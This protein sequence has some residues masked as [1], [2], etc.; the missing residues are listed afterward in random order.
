MS[1]P[2]DLAEYDFHRCKLCGEAAGEPRYELTNGATIWVCASCDFHYIDYLDLP[3]PV[4]DVAEQSLDPEDAR[5][6]QHQ[7]Q[8][9]G[10]RFDNQVQHVAEHVDLVGA[11]CMDIGAGGGK[12]LALL[13]ESGADVHGIEPNWKRRAFAAERYGLTLESEPLVPGRAREDAG[14]YDLVTLWD[15]VEHVNFPFEV[16][17]LALDLLRPGGVLAVDTPARDGAFHRAGEVGY[18]LTGGRKATF[19][20]AMYSPT[21]FAHKQI[22]STGD[23]EGYAR[24][25]G[26][27]LLTCRR[28]H[29]LSFPTAF[30]LERLLPSRR[31]ARGVAPAVGAAVQVAA[32]RNKILFMARKLKHAE[33]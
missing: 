12:F 25:R 21:P 15:V 5:Y 17:D 24:G 19:L 23:L 6:I 20:N 1:L 28:F 18:T 3:E 13:R 32:P 11:K 4:E 7:L 22:L 2:A 9:N 33:P 27:D 14:T 8:S 16:L 10:S 30:Y 31:L 26:L 29:E